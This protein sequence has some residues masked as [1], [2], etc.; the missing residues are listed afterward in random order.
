M[1]NGKDSDINTIP[2]T[3]LIES[4]TDISQAERDNYMEEL[5]SP[6]VLCPNLTEF[7]VKGG[8][9]SAIRLSL[10]LV[11]YP[12]EEGR[13]Y[14]GLTFVASADITKYFSAGDYKSLGFQ[15]A[16]TLEQQG[17]YMNNGSWQEVTKFIG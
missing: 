4:W 1:V 12:T 3:E 7:S 17:I 2:C 16:I 14:T 15:E 8:E 11:V 13:L 10:S 6:N 5:I 9:T